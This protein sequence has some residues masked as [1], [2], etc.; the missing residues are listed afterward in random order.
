[1]VGD[2][3]GLVD[4]YQGVGMDS[5]AL[6]GRLA[7][8]AIRIEEI[9]GTDVLKIYQRLMQK[10]VRQTKKNQG[11]GIDRFTTNEELQKY[12][13]RSLPKMGIV[14]MVQNFLNK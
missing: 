10:P 13:S 7:A 5:A 1:M 11:R 8:R 9:K 3:A 14:M 2:A 6:N 12:L 4:P